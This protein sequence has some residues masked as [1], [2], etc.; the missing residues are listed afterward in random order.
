MGVG[1]YWW[2][3]LR[4]E[5]DTGQDSPISALTSSGDFYPAAPA[6]DSF[7]ASVSI[8]LPTRTCGCA[9]FSFWLWFGRTLSVHVGNIYCILF[10]CHFLVRDLY[11]SLQMEMITSLHFKVGSS[12]WNCLSGVFILK[13]RDPRDG[14][15]I[16]WLAQDYVICKRN[17][18]NITK[19]K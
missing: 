18:A 2:H 3:F 14:V 15:G 4:L 19:Q 17:Q 16:M 5:G 11:L 1:P 6:A 8:S 7:R 13:M 10:Q 12:F 9:F